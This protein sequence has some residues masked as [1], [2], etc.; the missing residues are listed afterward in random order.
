MRKSR[1]AGQDHDSCSGFPGARPVPIHLPSSATSSLTEVLL[2]RQWEEWKLLQLQHQS[3][4]SQWAIS[5][6]P[7]LCQVLW[8]SFAD[9]KRIYTEQQRKPSIKGNLQNEL[10]KV[11][12][13][14]VSDKGL[15]F[16]IYKESIHH[17]G[18][19]DCFKPQALL[20]AALQGTPVQVDMV[21]VWT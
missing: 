10:E 20:P 18:P 4:N 2:A 6:H 15:I 19:L 11:F 5:E 14:S 17:E 1:T 9:L 13:N 12:A 21:P 7:D 16:I 8:A 3:T